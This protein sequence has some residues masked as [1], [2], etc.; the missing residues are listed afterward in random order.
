[1]LGGTLIFSRYIGKAA[2]GVAMNAAFKSKLYY[3]SMAVI[4][5]QFLHDGIWSNSYLMSY[6]YSFFSI[7][8]HLN[9]NFSTLIICIREES[10]DFS[11]IDYP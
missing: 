5:V 10:S 1:M 11:A 8:N 6:L 9:L 7:A 3:F 4:L 2:F